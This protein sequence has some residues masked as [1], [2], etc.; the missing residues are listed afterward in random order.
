MH[1][2]KIII[3]VNVWSFAYVHNKWKIP[4]VKKVR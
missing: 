2:D 1:E 4:E 3:N